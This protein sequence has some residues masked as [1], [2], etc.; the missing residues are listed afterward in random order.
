MPKQGMRRQA[1]L[2]TRPCPGIANMQLQTIGVAEK[3]DLGV[4]R[5]CIVS[6]D[7][8]CSVVTMRL[9]EFTSV[10]YTSCL[11]CSCICHQAEH[12]GIEGSETTM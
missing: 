9:F 11:G 6:R 1:A 2:T 10:L 8:S 4:P 5:I 12:G 7:L 3:P